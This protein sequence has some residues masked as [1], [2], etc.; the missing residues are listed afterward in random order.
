MGLKIAADFLIS[1]QGQEW[2]NCVKNKKKIANTIDRF[3]Y[4]AGTCFPDKYRKVFNNEIS[5][6]LEKNT[7]NKF[8]D[9]IFKCKIKE[10]NQ[11]FVIIK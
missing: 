7:K 2:L 9:R 3:E 5:D 1:K 6:L 8:P 10:S 4:Y 11:I